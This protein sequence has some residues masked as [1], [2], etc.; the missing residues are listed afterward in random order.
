[1]KKSLGKKFLLP[2]IILVIIGLGATATASYYF[3]AQ[4]LQEMARS[5]INQLADGT[6]RNITTWL[7]ERRR[8][9][10]N[11][12]T[13]K[14]FETALQDGFVAKAARKSANTLLA[15]LKKNMNSTIP[16]SWLMEKVK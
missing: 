9:V 13:T 10:K 7:G 15:S 6:D 4:A 5:E 1:M 14:V 16:L 12:S 11:W 3:S 8:E 2:T